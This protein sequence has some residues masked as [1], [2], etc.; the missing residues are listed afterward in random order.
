VPSAAIAETEKKMMVLMVMVRDFG[1]HAPL[2]AVEA[3]RL[4]TGIL[5][6]RLLLSRP[7][8]K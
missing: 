3:I 4:A 5:L 2:F 6:S 1:E 7:S 8:E